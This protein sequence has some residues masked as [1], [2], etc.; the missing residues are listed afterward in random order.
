M[1][2][3][4]LHFNVVWSHTLPSFHSP[5]SSESLGFAQSLDEAQYRIGFKPQTPALVKDR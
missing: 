1:Q 3:P 5:L 4:A 2:G